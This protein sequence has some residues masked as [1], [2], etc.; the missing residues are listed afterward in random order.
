MAY[1]GEDLDLRTPQGVSP[2]PSDPFA[3]PDGVFVGNGRRERSNQGSASRTA[4]IW[5][6][7]TVLDCCNYAFDVALAHRSAEV[8]LE[9]LLYALTRIDAAA[10]I[11]ESRGLRVVPLRREMATFVATDIPVGLAAG[12]GTPR[13]SEA[14]EDTLR[15]AANRRLPAAGSRRRDRYPLCAARE[16]LEIAGMPRLRQLLQR[17]GA[18][19]CSIHSRPRRRTSACAFAYYGSEAPRAAATEIPQIAPGSQHRGQASR[20]E[21]LEH[22]IRTITLSE[23][24]NERK[25]ISGCCTTC[26]E[27]SWPSAKRRPASAVN[28]RQNPGSCS[29]TA[30]R[31]SSRRC[32]VGAPFRM[33]EGL[34]R[35]ASPPWSA[36]FSRNLAACARRFDTPRS[37]KTGRHLTSRTSSR[38]HRGSGAVARDRLIGCGRSKEGFCCRARP[39][40]GSRGSRHRRK[41]TSSRVSLQRLPA[42]VVA[43]HSGPASPESI[44]GLSTSL[45]ATFSKTDAHAPPSEFILPRYAGVISAMPSPWSHV[46]STTRS[47][48]RVATSRLSLCLLEFEA[49]Y[50]QGAFAL[51]RLAHRQSRLGIPR[52]LSR[53]SEIF[54]A[55]ERANTFTIER[56]Y[57]RQP[58]LVLGVR[59]STAGSFELPVAIGVHCCELAV[60]RSP[61]KR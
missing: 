14:L 9:H 48:R 16:R 8:R 57:R 34:L 36:R 31:A 15:V 28:A 60:F 39:I 20:L 17:R 10:E 3:Q 22:A 5:V 25:I 29:G 38:R 1:R 61:L 27:S 41:P 54:S 44:E 21:L 32:T 40:R 33:E 49:G 59:A 58:L 53:C 2:A 13:R 11:L 4:P 24:T 52:G 47:L 35:T 23:L 43:L 6:D 19:P 42:D 12:K 37:R 46:T 7:D 51:H 45:E 56:Y 18:R 30:C 26:S 55:V 50:G